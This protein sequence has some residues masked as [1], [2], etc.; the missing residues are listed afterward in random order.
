VDDLNGEDDPKSNDD[1]PITEYGRRASVVDKREIT[2]LLKRYYAI[3]AVGDGAAACSLI[4]SR[5]VEDP[6][7]TRTVPEDRYS[8]TV[9]PRVWPGESC[10]QVASLL[11]RQRRKSL[12]A[13]VATLRVTSV[14]VHDGHGVAL[15]GFR[16]TPRHWIPVV[17]EGVA[18]KIHAFLGGELP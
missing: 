9:S 12:I 17:R 3:A 15:L 18:W 1:L 10:A 4:Y 6:G 11:F 13:E 2:A 16:T 8:R 5:L 14:R 7:F